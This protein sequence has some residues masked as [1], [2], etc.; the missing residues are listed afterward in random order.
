MIDNKREK[1]TRRLGQMI[2]CATTWSCK[3]ER[4]E[5]TKERHLQKN[6]TRKLPTEGWE[7]PVGE[8]PSI[9]STR[10]S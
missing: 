7:T 8:G 6:N 10:S 5:K 9:T 4:T 2:Q 3:K 1:A